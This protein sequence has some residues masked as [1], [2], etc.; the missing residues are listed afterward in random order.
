M[1]C[2]DSKLE[3]NYERMITN[4]LLFFSGFPT[5]I[6]LS[7]VLVLSAVLVAPVFTELDQRVEAENEEL[8]ACEG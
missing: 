3:R 7:V 4:T 5:R 1:G 2:T 6:C 8:V